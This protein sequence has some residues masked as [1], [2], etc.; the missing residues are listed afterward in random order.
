MGPKLGPL[1][2]GP[3]GAFEKTL[4]GTGLKLSAALFVVSSLEVL[5][6]AGDPS[7]MDGDLETT[8]AHY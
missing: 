7:C 2:I 4:P 5:T 8:V 6:M 3:V 1:Y